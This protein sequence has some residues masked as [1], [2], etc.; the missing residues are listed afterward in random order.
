V[1]VQRGA[2]R[3]AL[4]TTSET[5]LAGARLPREAS[6]AKVAK[7]CQRNNDDDDDPKPGWHVI[8]FRW[9]H[10][11]ST[12]SR[13]VFATCAGLRRDWNGSRSDRSAHKSSRSNAVTEFVHP[14]AIWQ[15]SLLMRCSAG[16]ALAA[17]VAS[18]EFALSHCTPLLD[19]CR[20]QLVRHVDECR[21]SSRDDSLR[22]DHASQRSTPRMADVLDRLRITSAISPSSPPTAISARLLNRATDIGRDPA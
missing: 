2:L 14:H 5:K 4:R 19:L 20:K 13:P 15:T 9:E 8:P 18:G 1:A 7:D 17:V 12:T 11:D 21:A 6:P 16:T 22:R 3:R 10:A